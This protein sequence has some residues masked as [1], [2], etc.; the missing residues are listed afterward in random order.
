M[1]VLA[2]YFCSWKTFFLSWNYFPPEA[3]SD[4]GGAAVPLP[5]MGNG[6]SGSVP[7]QMPRTV[8]SSLGW[9]QKAPPQPAVLQRERLASST[10]GV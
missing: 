4:G 9:L 6:A 8:A 10:D 5:G 1:V 3:Q 2:L 7:L